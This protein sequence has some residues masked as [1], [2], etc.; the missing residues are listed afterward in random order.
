MSPGRINHIGMA[1]PSIEAFLRRNAVLYGGFA[2][3][4]I[5]ENAR[6]RV[7]EQFI[8]DGSTVIELLEPMGADSPISGFLKRNACGGLIHVALE[9]G[10]LET[11]IEA[12]CRAGGLLVAA[13]A[14]DVAFEDRRIAFVTLDGQIVELVEEARAQKPSD[15]SM[16]EGPSE[17][18]DRS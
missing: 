7:R 15:K 8:S 9:A 6:Q 2:R 16:S 12:V 10:N 13:P 11:A 17:S 5:I 14:P 18:S 1:V 4:P 3:G